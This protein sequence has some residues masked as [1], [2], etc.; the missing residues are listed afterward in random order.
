M[1][2]SLSRDRGEMTEE[3]FQLVLTKLYVV[4]LSFKVAAPDIRPSS[5]PFFDDGTIIIDLQY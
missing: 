1:S 2:L 4:R 3:V 5:S